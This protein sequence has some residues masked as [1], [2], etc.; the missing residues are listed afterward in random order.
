M[1]APVSL[2]PV[3]A[4]VAIA[5]D[6]GV[7]DTVVPTGKDPLLLGGL[8]GDEEL[9]GEVGVPAD[10]I[11]G[12]EP[13]GVGDVGGV[14]EVPAGGTGGVVVVVGGV[15][16]GAGGEEVEE[17]GVVGGGVGPEG[18]GVGV[19]EGVGV[20][21]GV[22]GVEVVLVG[23]EVVV[24]ASYHRAPISIAYPPPFICPLNGKPTFHLI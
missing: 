2:L 24:L 20:E 18:T 22:G 13:G 15:E 19:G 9:E 7:L 1:V 16:V 14:V 23:A 5:D 10:G 4:P 3:S 17:E 8:E 21:V 11:E 12:E 6:D